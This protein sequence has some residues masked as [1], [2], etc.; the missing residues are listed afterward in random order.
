VRAAWFA[1]ITS[2]LILFAWNASA[3][4]GAWSP[5][6]VL[7]PATGPIPAVGSAG[8]AQ[9]VVGPD[10]TATVVWLDFDGQEMIVQERRI[11]PGGAPDVTTYDLSASGQDAQDPQVAVGPDGAATVVW[12]RSD[13]SNQIVQ[14]RRIAPGGTPDATI[15]D[16][17][18]AGKDAAQPQLAVGSDGAATVVWQRS[19]GSN[20]IVQERR[21]APGG[22]PDAIHDLSEAGKDAAQPQVAVG[23]YGNATVVWE[24]SDGSNTIVQG[25]RVAPDGLPA[26]ATADLSASGQDANHP[27]VTYDGLAVWDRFDGT[28]R[29]I[30]YSFFSQPPASVA[31][32]TANF[33][34]RRVGSGPGPD[35]AFTITNIG[36]E[37]MTISSVMVQPPSTCC[38]SF[39]SKSPSSAPTA[40]AALGSPSEESQFSLG[41]ADSC[42]TTPVGVGSS[43]QVSVAFAPTTSCFHQAQLV[44]QGYFGGASAPLTGF[45]TPFISRIAK[46]KLNKQEGTALLPVTIGCP[47]GTLSLA[48]KGVV[49]QQ[50]V[51]GSGNGFA[52]SDR[53][54]LPIQ[55]RG[56]ARHRLKRSGETHINL[57]LTYALGGGLQMTDG[58]SD[59]E[60]FSLKLRKTIRR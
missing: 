43:C 52:P 58:S 51:I 37:P 5:P 53:A 33:G 21:I 18:A 34:Q 45:G 40:H 55:P 26:T 32:A 22:T 12:Q 59:S 56:R 23:P 6:Q 13:G 44:V 49:A 10:G 36:D 3:A 9:V 39:Y 2:A 14:E 38:P 41:H 46:A 7:L 29:V 57:T 1:G 50:Q 11:A 47:G 28:T 48:G 30:Q 31:P 35:V 20:T 4:L 17:S 54:S 42:T 15:H 27:Q 19:D 60:Q 24:R 8:A 16:L 25:R